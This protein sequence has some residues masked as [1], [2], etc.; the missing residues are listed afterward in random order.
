MLVFR[1]PCFTSGCLCFTNKLG[2]HSNIATLI[3]WKIKNRQSFPVQR[4]WQCSHVHVIIAAFYLCPLLIGQEKK[5]NQCYR[6]YLVDDTLGKSGK[7]VKKLSFN[8]IEFTMN[9][10]FL[11]TFNTLKLFQ[12]RLRFGFPFCLVWF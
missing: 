11:Y 6:F 7:L 3:R 4:T 2:R 12:F 10:C 9:Q 1:A 8:A 5:K